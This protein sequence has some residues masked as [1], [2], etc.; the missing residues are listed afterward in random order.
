MKGCQFSGPTSR[1]FL[2]QF[3]DRPRLIYQAGRHRW[4]FLDCLMLSAEII[5][6][7]E[8]RLHGDV[9][10]ERFAICIG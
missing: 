9:M 1:R 10:P 8:N 4:R 2:D 7:H 6:R 3:Y 5:E